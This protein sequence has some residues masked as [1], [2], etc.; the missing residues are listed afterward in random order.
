[1]AA[2]PGKQHRQHTTPSSASPCSSPIAGTKLSNFSWPRV[3]L[4]SRNCRFA[5]TSSVTCLEGMELWSFRDSSGA[6]AV[7]GNNQSGNSQ[8]QSGPS[9]N[10]RSTSRAPSDDT[11]GLGLLSLS[12][13]HTNRDLTIFRWQSRQ[14]MLWTGSFSTMDTRTP[15]FR[16]ATA[17]TKG[18]SRP[19]SSTLKRLRISDRR[20]PSASIEV[21]MRG[22]SPVTLNSVM[23]ILFGYHHVLRSDAKGCLS[24]ARWT[25][26]RRGPSRSRCGVGVSRNTGAKQLCTIV[27]SAAHSPLKPSV[28]AGNALRFGSS[29]ASGNRT[30][31]IPYSAINR[32][33]T[34]PTLRSGSHA[35][36]YWAPTE[37]TTM[38]FPEVAGSHLDR[39]RTASSIC[40][41]SSHV[42]ITGRPGRSRLVELGVSSAVH[43]LP[44]PPP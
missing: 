20:G 26:S 35:S 13:S 7:S 2:T 30:P 8:W 12:R 16:W 25:L 19:E 23:N 18:S 17:S 38:V 34:L 5:R 33:T 41:A 1:M 10:P 24:A 32:S 37:L 6:S 4:S 3:K 11:H 27:A 14:T 15:G 22:V 21:S 31:C 39:C 36:S 28:A 29:V 42:S 44:G 43:E 9:S 40:A